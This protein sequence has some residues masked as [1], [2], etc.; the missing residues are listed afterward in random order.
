[1]NSK[2][3]AEIRRRFR[4]EKHNMGAVRGCYVNEKGE[5]VAEFNQ[6]LPLMPEDEAEKFL[7]ILKR[8]LSGTLDK[9]L[10]DIEFTTQQVVEGEQHRMLMA[11]RDSALKDDELVQ[12]FF[13][14]VIQTVA[15]EDGYVILL[16]RDTYD[17]PY[18][19]KDGER[20]EDASS[21]VF[22]YI[23]CSICPVKLTK[24]ALS[25]YVHYNEFHSK[26]ADWIVAPP[27]LGFMFP[28]FDDRG[29]NL[30]NAL[31][32]T[33]DTTR[34][35]QE[36]IDAVFAAMVPLPAAEQKEAFTNV[37]SEALAQDCDFETVQ[38]VQDS[39][40]E[41]IELHKESKEPEN[42]SLDKGRFKQVLQANGVAEEAIEAFDTGYDAAFGPET[43]LS[44]K[45][46]VE[47][48]KV[49][50]TTSGVKIQVSPEYSGLVETQTINGAKYILIRAEEGVEL[51]GVPVVI[52]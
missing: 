6:A 16:V 18:R 7:S 37:L 2:E 22:S 24:P 35:Q 51:N 9:N 50:V 26:E 36:F 12:E 3:I 34:L 46:I 25:Y 13:R 4:P 32:Y 52:S 20:M 49:E 17:V 23:V 5:I 40:K 11:L 45:N 15:M 30:Y 48:G 10:I 21:E 38:A 42:L 1:M 27:E 41:M 8:T 28:S 31:Y 14:R 33:R 29:T 47:T 19:S 44:P 39:L 43:R